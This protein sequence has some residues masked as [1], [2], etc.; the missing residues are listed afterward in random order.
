MIDKP[1]NMGA[2]SLAPI[3]NVFK[4]LW[5]NPIIYIRN[6]IAYAI[7]TKQSI[8]YRSANDESKG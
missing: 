5:G 8:N 6:G 7:I 4:Y 1:I 2:I 3:F